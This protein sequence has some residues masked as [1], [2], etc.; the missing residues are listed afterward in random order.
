MVFGTILSDGSRL[1]VG[2]IVMPY[3]VNKSYNPLVVCIS[4]G[5]EVLWHQVLNG[6]HTGENFTNWDKAVDCVEYGGYLYVLID[7]MSEGPGSESNQ[8]NAYKV[9]KLDMNGDYLDGEV[10]GGWGNEYPSEI[11]IYNGSLVVCGYMDTN[12]SQPKIFVN[13]ISLDFTEM[14]GFPIIENNDDNRYY[15]H[16][17]TFKGEIVHVTGRVLIDADREDRLFHMGIN[18]ETKEQAYLRFVGTGEDI[19]YIGRGIDVTVDGNVLVGGLRKDTNY[20]YFLSFLDLSLQIQTQEIS[21]NAGWN[22]ISFYVQPEDTDIS[23]VLALVDCEKVWTLFEDVWYL[24]DP[25]NPLF[26]DLLEMYAGQGYMIKMASAATLFVSGVVVDEAIFLSSGWEMPGYLS[27]T[28]YPTEDALDSIFGK[29]DKVWTIEDGFWKLYD[30][31][32]LLFSD[33]LEMK[34][35]QGYMMKINDSCTWTVD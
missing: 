5:G 34:P 33:L 17:S 9:V 8:N 31:A 14:S 4:S 18:L 2:E 3:A 10:F 32:N 35:G 20:D 11:F 19:E 21:L 29:Y 27:A 7:T 25:A 24:Y 6:F 30:P 1:A 23:V 22:L 15:V 12:L 28:T 26:S 13:K 16:A